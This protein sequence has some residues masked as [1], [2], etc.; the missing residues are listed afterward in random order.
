[1]MMM[2]MM[3]GTVLALSASMAFG[4]PSWPARW[5]ATVSTK[6]EASY[7]HDNQRQYF[8]KAGTEYTSHFVG[9]RNGLYELRESSLTRAVDFSSTDMKHSTNPGLF[10]TQS[11]PVLLDCTLDR[12]GSYAFGGGEERCEGA[13]AIPPQETYTVISMTAPPATYTME[14]D[15]N[16]PFGTCHYHESGLPLSTVG[17][18]ATPLGVF[19]LDIQ[20]PFSIVTNNITKTPRGSWNK[21]ASGDAIYTLDWNSAHKG[22]SCLSGGR[23]GGD[24]PC[25]QGKTEMV[26]DSQTHLPRSIH[27][28]IGHDEKIWDIHSDIDT[29]SIDRVFS[30][31]SVAASGNDAKIP[32]PKFTDDFTGLTWQG[33]FDGTYDCGKSPLQQTD[34]TPTCGNWKIL[35]WKNICTT[36]CNATN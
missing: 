29:I 13:N 22:D 25:T 28:S 6:I 14:Y 23:S 15:T 30:F 17:S 3:Q 7:H 21:S 10:W 35:G 19:A 32:C 33:G 12:N 31:H 16:N 18:V 5:S 4:I 11:C 24:I 2:M 20:Q 36:G 1:M 26:W 34:L 8:A 27:T 9:T